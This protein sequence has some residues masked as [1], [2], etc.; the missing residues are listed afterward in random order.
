LWDNATDYNNFH[1]DDADYEQMPTTLGKEPIP[2]FENK[3]VHNRNFHWGSSALNHTNYL[4][5]EIVEGKDK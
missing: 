2:I 4:E 1:I 3:L 5:E